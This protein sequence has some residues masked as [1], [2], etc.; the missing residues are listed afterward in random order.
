METPICAACGCSLVRLGISQEKAVFYH[1]NEKQY[2]FCCDGC[3]ELFKSQP[4]QLLHET[5]GLVVCPVCLAEKP[6]NATVAHSFN[7]V[8]FNFCRCPYCLDVFKQNQEFYIK[9]LAWQTDYSGI[10]GKQEA[11]CSHS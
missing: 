4:E 9:R 8:I 10:F 6:I 11:C 3:L 5:S 2:W 1:Y 7:G